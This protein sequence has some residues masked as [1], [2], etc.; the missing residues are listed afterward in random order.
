MSRLIEAYLRGLFEEKKVSKKH[1]EQL[2]QYYY[3]KLSKGVDVGFS[4]KSLHYDKDLADAL[5]YNIAEFSAFKET[6]FRKVVESL[7]VDENGG[8]RSWRDFKL[9]AYKVSGDYNHH[10]LE[11]EYHQTIANAQMAEKWKGFEDNA[12]LYPNLKL[13][14]VGDARVRPEHKILDGT[15]RPIDDPFWKTHTPPLD[16]GCRC[17]IIATDEDPTEI[18]GGLQLKIEFENNPALTGKIFGGSAYMTS[19]GLNPEM[20]EE[21]GRFAKRMFEKA[22]DEVVKIYEKN[23]LKRPRE[24]QFKTV[25]KTKNGGKVLKHILY[26][27]GNDHREITLAAK[28]FAERGSEVEIM[29]E[30]NRKG[31]EK[32]RTVVFPNYNLKKNPDLRI[33]GGYYDVKRVDNIKNFVKNANRASNQNA[34]AVLKYDGKDLTSE[35]MN[36]VKHRIFSVNNVNPNTGKHNYPFNHFYF[37]HNGKLYKQKRD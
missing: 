30:I 28:L 11:T 27:K 3:D 21:I 8:L 18:K 5:K 12:D 10:W 9:E 35:M 7:L 24:N 37:L 19:G 26:K 17:D 15:I 34:I 33:D 23:I 36:R 1:R 6:S 14:S 16:W 13:V 2:W 20:I 25:L 22:K 32:F 31:F 4:P 29:P